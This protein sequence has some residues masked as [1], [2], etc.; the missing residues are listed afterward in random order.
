MIDRRGFI[1]GA[2]CFG[3]GLPFMG[4]GAV[5]AAA[6][7]GSDTCRA[8]LLCQ[9]NNAF[10]DDHEI[11][12][13]EDEFPVWDGDPGVNPDELKSPLAAFGYFL[14]GRI[15]NE[16]DDRLKAYRILGYGQFHKLRDP[17][18]PENHFM[19]CASPNE[20]E[21]W[22]C[23]TGLSDIG[24]DLGAAEHNLNWQV[25]NNRKSMERYFVFWCAQRAR[26]NRLA[27]MT[28]VYFLCLGQRH[29]DGRPAVKHYR[30]CFRERP[31]ELFRLVSRLLGIDPAACG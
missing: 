24:A 16:P 28:A 29:Q 3:C 17:R 7:C 13:S 10:D 31:E 27:Q 12:D 15:F 18:R 20:D 26:P 25:E 22:F 23:L 2:L 30:S 1:R 8:E 19:G 11:D 14:R 4:R 21:F 6:Q 5:P 9:W